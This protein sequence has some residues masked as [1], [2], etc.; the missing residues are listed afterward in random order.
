MPGAGGGG[1]YRDCTG[2]W[3]GAKRC[4]IFTGRS[5]WFSARNST[6]F[7]AEENFWIFVTIQQR[8]THTISPVK[9]RQNRA[10]LALEVV[11]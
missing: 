9:W 4:D 8:V 3:P 11:G 7:A 1:W 10:A 6:L 2:A 5:F